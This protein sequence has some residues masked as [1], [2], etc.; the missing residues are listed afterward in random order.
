M[1]SE[2]HREEH[3]EERLRILDKLSSG[4]ITPAEAEQRL[5]ALG[6]EEEARTSTLDDFK[7]TVLDHAKDVTISTAPEIHFR[8]YWNILLWV[9]IVLLA[10]AGLCITTVAPALLLF[11]GWSFLVL[12]LFMVLVA[13]WSRGSRW[14]HIRVRENNGT[15]FALSLPVPLRLFEIG[16][17]VARRFVRAETAQ[18]LDMASSMLAMMKNMETDEPLMDEPI[19]IE[20]D[21]DDGDQVQVYFG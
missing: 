6:S 19:M 10:A 14:V 16:L 21:D 4:Q 9:G 2:E 17:R 12:G 1:S 3:Q 13:W 5:L 18:N 20:V 11:C 8:R 7:Q 15:K